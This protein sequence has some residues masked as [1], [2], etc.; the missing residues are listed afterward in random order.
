MSAHFLWLILFLFLSNF[1]IALFLESLFSDLLSSSIFRLVINFV[2]SFYNPYSKSNIDKLHT[3][4]YSEEHRAAYETEF[5]L[6]KKSITYLILFIY[7]IVISSFNASVFIDCRIV[8]FHFGRENS[9]L[10]ENIWFHHL[11]LYQYQHDIKYKNLDFFYC[12]YFVLE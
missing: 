4:L 6:L 1:T 5:V 10:F 12:F 11:L 2:S 9:F 3:D 8:R 7:F